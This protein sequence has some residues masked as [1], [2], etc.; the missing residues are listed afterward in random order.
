MQETSVMVSKDNKRVNMFVIDT[1]IVII[2]SDFL[3][4]KKYHKKDDA[5]VKISKAMSWL[6]RHGA[7]LEGIEINADGFVRMGDVLNYFSKKGQAL[8][9]EQIME[10]VDT[11]DKKRFEV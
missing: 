9:L 5:N 6:L 2:F 10:I 4:M 3:S 11:N 1:L 8:K 7:V